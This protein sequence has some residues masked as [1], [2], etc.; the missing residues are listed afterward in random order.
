MKFAYQYRTSDNAQHSGVISASDR[1]SAFAALKAKGIKPF[2]L[3]EAPGLF[4]KLFGK[5]KR[6]IAIV[7]LSLLAVVLAVVS[8]SKSRTIAALDQT[9][10]SSP[11]H[12]IYGEPFYMEEL[13]RD[14][15]ASV[16]TH[17]GER[18]LAFFAQPGRIHRFSDLDWR[19]KMADAL[20]A[21]MTNDVAFKDGER[22][23]DKELKS[24]VR[25]MKVELARYLADGV[26]TPQ[27]YVRRLEER[28]TQEFRIYALAE[29]EL[30]KETDREKIDERNEALR[31]IGLPTIVAKE[32]F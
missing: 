24:I 16:F 15:Y 11:R 26:G 14:G 3:V 17:E 23:E 25:G 32:N 21:A 1:E 29:M 30:S 20:P 7:A 22:R 6:W 8:A 4:N 5:G 27:S 31:N 2:G 13:E 10:R 19:R 9:E 28:Q 18:Y 12:Q